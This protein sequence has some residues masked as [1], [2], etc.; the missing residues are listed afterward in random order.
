MDKG[1][2][3]T[4]KILI[5]KLG[6]QRDEKS[7]AKLAK[8]SSK[9][10][11]FTVAKHNLKLNY[12]LKENSDATTEIY[13]ANALAAYMQEQKDLRLQKY[14]LV[15]GCIDRPINGDEQIL[16]EVSKEIERNKFYILCTT[17]IMERLNDGNV[18]LLN[19]LLN[20]I[21]GMYVRKYLDIDPEYHESPGCLLDYCFLER[22]LI[23][24]C[25]KP[26]L[27]EECEASVTDK[28]TA[29]LLNRELRKISVPLYIRLLDY[30]KQRTIISMGIAVITSVLLNVLASFVTEKVFSGTIWERTVSS[31]V[32]LVILCILILPFFREKNR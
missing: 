9:L 4:Q 2:C 21:Y 13:D 6:Q 29:A 19:F 10:L 18:S 11:H 8:R 17:N 31:T 16:A 1:K 3:T 27:C 15:L 5:I 24:G 32:P 12:T 25:I 28:V 14:D 22:D 30:I 23:A 7:Y 26:V 20:I